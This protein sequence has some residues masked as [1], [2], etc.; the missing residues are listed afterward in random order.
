MR[1]DNC[2]LDELGVLSLVKGL[3]RLN[4][5]TFSDYP[6]RMYS[7]LIG[8]YES[9]W[10]SLGQTSTQI[11]RTLKGD[12]SDTIEIGQG[13]DVA[14]FGD[15]LG[16]VICLAGQLRLKDNGTQ[17]TNLGLQTP[18]VPNIQN[19]SQ[20]QLFLNGTWTFTT[21]D[22][23]EASNTGAYGLTTT[24]GTAIITDTLPGVTNTTLIGGG[25]ADN[26][27]DDTIQ[28]D[29]IPD[30][31][32]NVTQVRIEFLLN[33]SNLYQYE[34]DATTLTQGPQALTTFVITRS[35][36]T[37]FGHAGTSQKSTGVLDWTS[38]TSVKFTVNCNTQMNVT[39][40]NV[41]ITGGIQGQISGAYTYIQVNVNNN[42]FYE[43]LSPPSIATAQITVLNGCVV[44]QG[45]PV[46]TQVN[47][48]WFYR[49]GGTLDQYYRVGVVNLPAGGGEIGQTPAPFTDN[50]SDTEVLEIDLPLN[51]Y[52]LTWAYNDVNSNNTNNIQDTIYCVEGL[53]YNRMLFMG[54][55]FIYISDSLDP[56]AVDSRYILKAFGDPA[57]TNLWIKKITNAV[58][59]LGTNKNLY[60]IT[61][62]FNPLPDGTIDVTI[63]PIGEN[64]PPITENVCASQGNIFYMAADGIRQTNGSNSANFSPPLR[65]LFEGQTRADVPPF[66]ISQYADYPM[67]IGKTRLYV[68]IPSTDG[69]QRLFVYDLL[70]N[71]WRFQETNPVVI[72]TTPYDNV[73]LGYNQYNGS[74]GG[75]IYQ[76]D[77]G[78][79]VTGTN[80]D[81]IVGFPLE[82]RTVFDAN[83][84]PRNR[85]DTFTLKIIAD[86]GNFPCSVYIAKDQEGD[87]YQ[88]VGNFQSDGIA[89]SYFPLDEFTLGFRYSIRIVDSGDNPDTDV[90]GPGLTIFKLYELTIEYEAR[91]EQLD[92]LYIQ[93]NN[94]GTNSRK[95]M[96]GY[97]IIIDTLG[98]TIT[99]TPYID[100][101]NTGILPSTRT[102]STPAKQT[103]IYYYE[104][105][106]I[107]TDFNLIL[108]GGV[109]EFYG[110]ST[111]N[112]L[113]SEKMP[114]P[115]E[116]LVIPNND[117]GTPNRKRHSSYKFQIDT[118]GVPVIYTPKLDGVF[119][120]PAEYTT[121]EKRIVEYF[122]GADTIAREVGGTLATTVDGTPF[123]FYGVITPQT[124]EKLPD[125]LTY[126]RIPND[127]LGI[128]S[129]KRVRTLPMVI[130]TYG[131]PVTYNPI[132]DG[133]D[134]GD[135]P[136]TFITDGKTTVWYYFDKDSFGID[137]GGELIAQDQTQPFEFYGMGKPEDVEILP[138]GKILDQIGP[139]RFDKVGKIFAIRLRLIATGANLSVTLYGDSSPT[140]TY[141]Q[142]PIYGPIEIEVNS[143]TD[144]V[145]EIQLPKSINT[146]ILRIVLG[147][148]ANFPFYRYDCYVKVSMSGMESDSKWMPMR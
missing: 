128:A 60:E 28:F 69:S 144:D 124:I 92:Y 129:R 108:S 63:N 105:E 52:L 137:Y 76:L 78:L 47:E 107:G 97:A 120:T 122:F 23:E 117:Y 35:Q 143:L 101:S 148:S 113:V 95:R 96:T 123:E 93:P 81:L 2:Y 145:Y 30:D 46:E 70:N 59:I 115:A 38:V 116:F 125:R 82:I 4:P 26:P 99:A 135:T 14:A 146:D 44:I 132:V 41:I 106:Q 134:P 37:R 87:P 103:Y 75:D 39:V 13:T 72:C 25:V 7:K 133:S 53:F 130:D 118:R 86:T 109:F 64:H 74:D 94:L 88:F 48:V 10:F 51:P 139:F 31:P 6:Y 111:L 55:S 61:G 119:L 90:Y 29:I 91:P 140:L 9:K 98:N 110:V 40:Q 8:N 58:C 45:S 1:M 27:D 34:C 56:D 42:G 73:L 5:T 19:V 24:E 83:G 85:K 65:L 141:N 17:I 11:L 114:V 102:F 142:E 80:G 138:V 43:A 89:T 50:L 104:Q 100:N 84:Q 22:T 67:A 136:A 147:P 36:F 33:E 131:Y 126:Y 68:S 49:G 18:A 127:N 21:G 112:E 32:S 3:K 71:Y 16:Q 79:G 20:P 62:T 77:T 12:F 15:C 66:V 54:A 121:T 57:E